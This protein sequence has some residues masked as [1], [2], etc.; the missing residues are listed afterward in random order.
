MVEFLANQAYPQE[1]TFRL[2]DKLTFQ[3]LPQGFRIVMKMVE[4]VHFLGDINL[5]CCGNKIRT[6]LEVDLH[7]I[8]TS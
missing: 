1:C 6:E 5:Y 4:L 8:M 7:L 3:L 2:F